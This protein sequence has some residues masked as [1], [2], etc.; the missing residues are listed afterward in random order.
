MIAVIRDASIYVFD[1]S[2]L[3]IQD[4]RVRPRAI[5]YFNAYPLDNHLTKHS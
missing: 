4:G 5:A 2:T 3:D 1:V